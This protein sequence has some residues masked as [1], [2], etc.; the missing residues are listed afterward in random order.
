MEF[1]KLFREPLEGALNVH[2]FVVDELGREF[3]TRNPKD[4][5]KEIIR[6]N[7]HEY[8]FIGFTDLGGRFRRRTSAEQVQFA[9][10]AA[11]QGL[12]VIPPAYVDE[13]DVPYYRFLNN[14]KTID[15]FMQEASDADIDRTVYDLFSDLRSA[16]KKSIVYGDRWT[17]NMLIAP[18]T[19]LVHIDFDLE[20][21]GKFTKEFE[22]AGVVYHTLCAGRYRALPTIAKI[23]ALNPDWVK[24]RVFEH[25]LTRMA[26]FFEKDNFRGNCVKETS[27]LLAAMHTL[28]PQK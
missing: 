15:K 2:E 21:Y 26:L 22:L 19:G 10:N 9:T 20:I 16:H 23:L 17:P 24:P 18:E 4:T 3:L 12:R 11:R 28:R 6:K 8:H 1:R 14:A 13:K 27:I 25:F 7:A 5:T